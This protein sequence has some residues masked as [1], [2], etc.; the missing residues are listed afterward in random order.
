M[1][2][3]QLMGMLYSDDVLIDVSNLNNEKQKPV[4]PKKPKITYVRLKSALIV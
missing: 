2:K 1:H 4:V 3:N